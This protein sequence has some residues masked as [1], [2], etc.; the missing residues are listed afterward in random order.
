MLM[1]SNDAAIKKV[2]VGNKKPTRRTQERT[3]ITRAKLLEAATRLFTENGFEGVSIRDIENDAEVQRGLLAYHFKDKESLWKAMADTTFN[4]LH[5]QLNPRLELLD[6][7]AAKEKI[8][9]IIRFYVRFSSRHP[10]LSRLLSQE[11]RHDSWRIRYLVDRHISSQA[12]GLREAVTEAL[13]FTER[14][15]M[16]WYYLLAGGSSLIFSHAPE[17]QLLFG[18]DAHEDSVVD[19]HAEMMVTALLG[20][21]D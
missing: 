5:D 14:E 12:H 3:E 16:H 6:D 17:C 2:E 21:R 18:E 7:L 4:L 20:P 13:G 15:F 19:A 11:A 10:E 9:Y 1:S 8:A